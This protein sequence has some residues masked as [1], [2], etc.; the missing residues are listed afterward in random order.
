MSTV[1]NMTDTPECR[2]YHAAKS[3][4]NN[5]KDKAYANYG[6]RGIEFRFKSFLEFYAHIGPK[7]SP[8]HSLDR[9]RNGGHYELGNVKWST[10][11]EQAI[12]RRTRRFAGAKGAY[13][14]EGRK[15]PWLALISVR[16]KLMNLGYYA[17]EEEAHQAYVQAKEALQ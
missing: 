4:C 13:F 15:K 17:T 14:Q 5:P 1:H 10:Q 9:I 3:R 2:A 7:P 8:K 6:G 12:N 11:R 16:H